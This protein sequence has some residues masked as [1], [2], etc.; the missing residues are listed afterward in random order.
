MHH[1]PGLSED[2]IKYRM[3]YQNIVMYL[4]TIP[5]YDLEEEGDDKPKPPVK[6]AA[7]TTMEVAKGVDLFNMFLKSS[8]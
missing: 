8:K 5:N 6:K 4:A 7:A 3:S 2:H 1:F